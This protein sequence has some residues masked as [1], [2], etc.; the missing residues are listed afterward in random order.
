VSAGSIDEALSM[1][2][3]VIDRQLAEPRAPESAWLE[4]RKSGFGASEIAALYLALGIEAPGYTPKYLAEKA[5]RVRRRGNPIRLFGEKA[6]LVKSAKTGRAA[7]Q[8]TARERELLKAWA[9]QAASDSGV[10]PFTVSHSD[11][12]PRCWYPLVDRVEPRLLCTPDAW[13][14]DANGR[15]VLI[16]LKCS[17]GERSEIPWYWSLQCHAEL[18]VTG[19]DVA[20]LVCGERW[21]ASWSTQG[22]GPIR[23]WRVE[24]DE[25]I[26]NDIR[27]LCREGWIE[28]QRAIDNA[29]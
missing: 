5:E 27:G 14:M 24:R 4:R 15:N 21:A 1:E 22:D 6:G 3:D 29:R 11:L 9:E 23:T 20:L 19:A 7:S 28:V 8:G 16:E 13:A 17:S 18:A 2:L 25:G 10:L 12:A 26:C